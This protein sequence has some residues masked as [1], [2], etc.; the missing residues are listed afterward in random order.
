MMCVPSCVVARRVVCFLASL[1]LTP[2]AFY[3]RDQSI[4]SKKD[5]FVKLL[6]LAKPLNP[7]HTSISSDFDVGFYVPGNKSPIGPK[8]RAQQKEKGTE[9][10][11][12]T[13]NDSQQ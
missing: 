8:T 11:L 10:T 3:A 4:K 12:W 6:W 9:D 5:I 1:I 2:R 7:L 13:K